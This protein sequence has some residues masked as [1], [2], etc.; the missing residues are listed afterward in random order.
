MQEGHSTETAL[1]EVLDGVCTAADKK[2]VVLIGTDLSAGLDT[3]NHE[4]LL[5]C[6]KSEFE[7]TSAPGCVRI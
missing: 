5:H 7:I 3:V 4:I 2:A 1:L 6:L